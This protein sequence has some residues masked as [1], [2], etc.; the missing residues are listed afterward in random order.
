MTVLSDCRSTF[1]NNQILQVNKMSI[2][3]KF[4][5]SEV[6]ALINVAKAGEKHSV[7][8]PML[9]EDKYH[10]G[11][12][13]KMNKSW[14]DSKNIDQSKVP[15]HLQLV[16]DQGV[17]LI[18]SSHRPKIDPVIYAK[19]LNPVVDNDWYD[20]AHSGL[21][22]DDFAEA[23]MLNDLEGKLEGAKQFIVNMTPKFYEITIK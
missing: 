16:K 14:P 17:Y 2:K 19:N 6:L 21:G 3:L 4:K 12:K 22:G 18:A 7:T 23:I 20:L 5:A 8:I 1:T 15:P 10:K 13:V 9:F 11:G